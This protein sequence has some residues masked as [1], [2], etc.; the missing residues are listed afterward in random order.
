MKNATVG[1][2]VALADDERQEVNG[3]QNDERAT[4]CVTDT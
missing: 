3:G 2:F 1:R 4:R